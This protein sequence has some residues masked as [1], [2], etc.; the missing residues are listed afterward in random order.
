MKEVGTVISYSGPNT[1][2]FWFVLNENQTLYKGQL[3]QLDSE[4][5]LMVARVGEIVKINRYYSRAESV[6]EY[7]R[8]GKPLVEQFPVN[9]WEYMIARAIPLGVW[10]NGEQRRVSFP[11][12][13]GD[14]V[15]LAN[16]NLLSKFF[17]LDEEGINIGKLEFHQLD[18]KLNLTRLF[19]KHLVILA[20]S[21]SGKSHLASVLIE[22]ILDLPKERSKPSIIVVDPHGEYISFSRDERYSPKT[23]IWSS[24]SIAIDTSKL[25]AS[26][27]AELI[28]QMSWVQRR[29]LDPVVKKLKKKKPCYS[30][31]ELI[32]EVERGDINP[33]TKRALVSWLLDLEST[34]FFKNFEKPS[35]EELAR[36]G[37]LSILDLSEMI[38]LKEKQTIVAYFARRLFNARRNGKIPPFILIIEEAHQFAPEGASSAEAISRG[39]IEQIAREGRK[40]CASLVLISQRPIKLSTTT[41]SQCNTQIIMRITNPYDLKHIGESSEGI[42]SDILKMLPGLKVGEAFVVGEAINYPTLVRIRKRKSKKWVKSKSLEDVLAEYQSRAK[43]RIEDLNAFK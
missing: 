15:M 24:E 38:R 39:I 26:G 16:K 43:E 36:Q 22:E 21:G 18:A 19:Q 25:S 23:K 17:G 28:P 7:E 10:V 35:V 37:Q 13:P 11:P 6:S 12:S 29:E 5:G 40:F 8:S 1:T 20:I 14:K 9:R 3:V 4:E 34:K 2:E 41:L 32:G 42:T 31:K 27:I 33:K 30:L